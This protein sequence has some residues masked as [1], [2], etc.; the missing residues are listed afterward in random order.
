MAI[1]RIGLEADAA[2]SASVGDTNADAEAPGLFAKIMAA[3]SVNQAS[4]FVGNPG[5]RGAVPEKK[6]KCVQ[7]KTGGDI[8]DIESKLKFAGLMG[9][10]GNI[11]PAGASSPEGIIYDIYDRDAFI[12]TVQTGRHFVQ[13]LASDHLKSVGGSFWNFNSLDF[14]SYT[15]KDGLGAD[16]SSHI[17]SLQ[18]TIGPKRSSPGNPDGAIG[19]SDLDCNNPAQDLNSFFRHNV[20]LLGHQL[21]KIFR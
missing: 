17:R 21:G 16:S 1:D 6:C 4:S 8:P 14:R 12:K 20:P 18:I 10:I 19:Y 3:G 11:R 9:L 2:K 7:D 5:E 15:D 13:D